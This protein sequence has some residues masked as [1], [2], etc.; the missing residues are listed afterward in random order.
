MIDMEEIERV[1]NMLDDEY[2]EECA[3]RPPYLMAVILICSVIG[4]AIT[5]LIICRSEVDRC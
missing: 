3:N 2:E 5:A 1:G 4:W